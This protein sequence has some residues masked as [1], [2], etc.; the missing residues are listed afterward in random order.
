[1]NGV[2]RRQEIETTGLITDLLWSDPQD[3]NGWGES[4]RGAGRIFGPDKTQ[5]FL[6]ANGLE[7]IVRSHQLPTEGGY[8]IAHDGKC[9]TVWNAAN[10]CN[11]CGNSASVGYIGEDLKI[12]Y[13][14]FEQ[15]T[16]ETQ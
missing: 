10:Y 13:L 2:E 16:E 9:V 12:Q 11:S 8:T 4:P 7:Y 3:D 15:K 6:T 1:M 5:E 14:V